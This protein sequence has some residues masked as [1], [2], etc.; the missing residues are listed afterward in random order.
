LHL[1]DKHKFS[2]DCV[3]QM[4]EGGAGGLVSDIK[5]KPLKSAERADGVDFAPNNFSLLPEKLVKEREIA[6]NA[7]GHGVGRLQDHFFQELRE[8]VHDK[9][10]IEQF[11]KSTACVNGMH[12]FDWNK[13]SESNC[14]YYMGKTLYHEYRNKLGEGAHIS[15][16]M[17]AQKLKEIG[18]V[19]AQKK[20][21]NSKQADVMWVGF[22]RKRTDM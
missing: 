6:F 19:K 1:A 21:N 4:V 17:F 10:F 14:F 22:K 15:T 20:M 12:P 11:L 9:A 7:I 16:T 3:K 13:L 5:N 8:D 2:T 18:L